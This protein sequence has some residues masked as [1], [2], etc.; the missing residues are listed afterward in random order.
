MANDGTNKGLKSKIYKQ[1]I[2]IN[3]KKKCQKYAE[4]LNRH[5]SKKIQIANRHMKRCST[6]LI[7]EEIQLK[8]T[9]RYLSPH[10]SQKTI[11]KNL[12]IINAGEGME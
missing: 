8:T 10:T 4:D 6:L 12:Q 1:L 9:M 11:I 3:I 2:Q 7:I 5:S